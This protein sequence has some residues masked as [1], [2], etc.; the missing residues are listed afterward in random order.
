MVTV[1]LILALVFYIYWAPWFGSY[2]IQAYAQILFGALLA[3][4]L[5][6]AAGYAAVQRGSIA[7]LPLTLAL[8]ALVQFSSMPEPLPAVHA[9]GL[10]ISRDGIPRGAGD[11]QWLDERDAL[12]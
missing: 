9:V 4:L 5:D 7:L 12:R 1:A 2:P 3:L 10:R 11:Q 8:L 6:E